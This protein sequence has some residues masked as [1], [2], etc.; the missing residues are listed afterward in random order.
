[1]VTNTTHV[2]PRPTSVAAKYHSFH[3]YLQIQQWEGIEDKL[4]PVEWGWKESDGRLVPVPTDLPPAPD[5]L[6]QVIRCNCQM[7]CSTMRYTCNTMGSVLLHV[8]IA[9]DLAA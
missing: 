3:V 1:M 8:V 5:E 9:E 7:D 2:H 4:L 6:V